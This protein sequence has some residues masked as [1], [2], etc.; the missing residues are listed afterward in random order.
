LKKSAAKSKD[1]ILE[2][3]EKLKILFGLYEKFSKEGKKETL[4]ESEIYRRTAEL[5]KQLG[6]TGGD[7]IP[8]KVLDEYANTINRGF[9]G[10][11]EVWANLI[12]ECPALGP[13]PDNLTL[14]ETLGGVLNIIKESL[15]ELRNLGSLDKD[16]PK[17]AQLAFTI[18]YNVKTAAET[19]N[20]IL[21]S[22]FG[23]VRKELS[24][25][26]IGEDI[27]D[28]KEALEKLGYK[29]VTYRDSDFG[30]GFDAIRKATEEEIEEI[31]AITEEQRRRKEEEKRRRKEEKAKREKQS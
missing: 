16:D 7:A 25:I 27:D 21:A 26:K 6:F 1:V 22:G 9:M 11:F 17:P 15:E 19:I 12:K 4:K 3:E 8:R 30:Q 29:Y 2:N 5:E 14:F 31:K 23:K 24:E 10:C 13:Q 18:D 20:K 28:L